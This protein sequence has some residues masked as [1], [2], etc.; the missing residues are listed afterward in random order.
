MPGGGGAPVNRFFLVHPPFGSRPVLTTS[1]GEGQG[2]QL[3]RSK[4]WGLELYFAL[5]QFLLPARC[6]TCQDTLGLGSR[7]V[8]CGTCWGRVRLLD[9][10]FCPRC[11]RPF[12]GRGVAH[13]VSHHC[14]G[15][16]LRQPHYLLA[17]SALLYE[18]D[19]PLREILLLF[20]HGRRD[21][22]GGHLGRLMADRATDLFEQPAFEAIVPVPLHRQRK[23]E[24]GF[25]QAE[26][27]AS[28][29]GNRLHRPVLR[30]AL[31]RIR[32][33]PPQSG[34]PRERIRNVRGAFA[35][36]HR[37]RVE[38]RTLLLVDDVFTTG[39]TVNECA[40]VM[41]K[42]GARAVLVYTLARAL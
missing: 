10:P 7:S 20:K 16:R 31:K 6:A 4:R 32:A 22:L 38:G 17:R 36:T 21:A 24:R 23:R 39:A 3:S 25:N 28:V 26:I 15:C 29:V 1:V 12:W 13:P 11:G 34:K 9:P 14:Q 2:S 33:T 5:L 19:D 30:K 8:V 27:L 37:E 40:K 42:S 18:R 41:M 35:V